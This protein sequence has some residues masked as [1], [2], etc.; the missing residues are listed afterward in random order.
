MSELAVVMPGV[1]SGLHLHEWPKHGSCYEDDKTS[2]DAGATPDE[3][4]TEVLALMRQLN[5]S[6]VRALFA[7][8]LGEVLSREQIEAA[9]DQ[10][11]G[12]GAAQRVIIKCNGSGGNAAISE[13]WIGL[14]GDITPT[15]DLAGL[16][17]AAPPSATATDEHSCAKGRVLAVSAHH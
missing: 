13:L 4:F 6:P 15:T 1:Q 2:A 10:A 7:D 17:L 16:I 11:F 8:H 14:K 3:Y 9:F 5:N 12:A